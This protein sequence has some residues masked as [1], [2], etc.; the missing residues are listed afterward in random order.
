VLNTSLS[1][2]LL[3]GCNAL[4]GSLASAGVDCIL[5]MEKRSNE[6]NREEHQL[7]AHLQY[8][9]CKSA[10]ASHVPGDAIRIKVCTPPP[11]VCV[12]HVKRIKAY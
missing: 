7:V 9:I 10:Q 2:L 8:Q 12:K 4:G 1:M 11:P 6:L 5:G 3:I